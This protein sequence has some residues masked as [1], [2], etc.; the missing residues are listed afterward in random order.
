MSV[1]VPG[2]SSGGATDRG[3][4]ETRGDQDGKVPEVPLAQEDF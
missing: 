2:T 4:M 3:P 1:E